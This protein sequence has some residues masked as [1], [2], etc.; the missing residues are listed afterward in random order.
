MIPAGAG[1][2]SFTSIAD[3]ETA[4]TPITMAKYGLIGGRRNGHT[5]LFCLKQSHFFVTFILSYL[6]IFYKKLL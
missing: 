4:M 3:V 5:P 1:A 2:A 6:A